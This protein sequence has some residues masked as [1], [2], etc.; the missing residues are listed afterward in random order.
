MDA[1]LQNVELFISTMDQIIPKNSMSQTEII[2]ANFNI[3]PN[4]YR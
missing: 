3:I 2:F 1:V 4:T